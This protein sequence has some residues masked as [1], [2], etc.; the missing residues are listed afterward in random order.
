MYKRQNKLPLKRC[1]LDESLNSCIKV[2]GFQVLGIDFGGGVSLNEHF[3][4]PFCKLE[5]PFV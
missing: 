2:Q 1:G 5:M 4:V 3:A